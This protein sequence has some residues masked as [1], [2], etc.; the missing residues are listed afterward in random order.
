MRFNQPVCTLFFFFIIITTILIKYST[1]VEQNNQNI[2][3]PFSNNVNNSNNENNNNNSIFRKRPL[4]GQ[5]VQVEKIEKH[6]GDFKNIP[7]ENCLK[8]L[9]KN[10]FDYYIMNES[11]P[12]CNEDSKMLFHIFWRGPIT[13]KLVFTMKSFL[14]SQPLNCSVLYIWIN[15]KDVDFLNSKIMHP[16]HKFIPDNIDFKTWNTEEQL[17]SIKFFRDLKGFKLVHSSVAF[18][19]MV[20][21]I[22][23]YKYGG[24]YIDADVLL[25]RDM[26]PLYY[27]NFEFSYHWSSKREYNT[28]VLRLWKNGT[29]ARMIL[30]GAVKNK[31]NF[32]PYRIRK[33]L[34]QND[35][36][37]EAN[38]HLYML[39]VGLFDPLW[40]K[41]D[42]VQT[43]STLEPNLN[44]I[45]D[46]FNPELLPL[47]YLEESINN[48][49][50][51][52]NTSNSNNNSTLASPLEFRKVEK[53]FRG[54]FAYHW[55]NNWRTVIEP[56]SWAGVLET[57]FDEFM[58][59]KRG[60]L[61]NEYITH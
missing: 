22:L 32:H 5:V 45:K 36:Y 4:Q 39:P 19:D 56:T 8:Y 41:N 38:K 54:I 20:R 1:I 60:N 33:Y 17:S 15:Y 24:I 42:K 44:K 61:Y 43:L 2:H 23:L 10:E 11:E 27:S 49:G 30:Q 37:E 55:H 50:N 26:R 6:C 25:I 53:F 29:T 21:F 35:S 40:L 31:M 57:A 51:K 48:D 9:D 14:F 16:L 28:A 18:S 46:F 52:N 47:E 59:G 58:V 3:S 12:I 34:S 13:D 7:V